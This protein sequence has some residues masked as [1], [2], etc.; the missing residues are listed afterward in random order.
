MATYTITLTDAEDLA[1]HYV[2]ISAQDWI[3]NVVK[4][5][6]RIA[7]KEIVDNHVQTQLSTGAPLAGTTHEEIVLNC[8]IKTLAQRDAEYIDPLSTPQ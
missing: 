4:D 3:E 1:L 7:M 6:C 2:A 8:G 5:R